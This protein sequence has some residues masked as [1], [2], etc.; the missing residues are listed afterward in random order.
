MFYLVIFCTIEIPSFSYIISLLIKIKNKFLNPY[1]ICFRTTYP[2]SVILKLI[3]NI[4][5][6]LVIS[7]SSLSTL[8]FL[9]NLKIVSVSL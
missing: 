4:F 3:W 8:F 5:H 2:Q 7:F 1:F 6:S 9:I